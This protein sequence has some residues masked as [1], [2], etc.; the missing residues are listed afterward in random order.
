MSIGNNTIY[1]QNLLTKINL[2]PDENQRDM[3]FENNF[4]TRNISIYE[5][6]RLK[7]IGN[8][9]FKNCKNLTSVNFPN[10]ITI[11]N[12]A[13]AFCSNLTSINFPNCITVDNYAFWG[14]SALASISFPNCTDIDMQAFRGCYNLS[15]VYLTGSSLCKLYNSNVFISTPFMG[16]SSYF[17][18]TP[19]IYVP[20]SLVTSYQNATNWTY[21]S[22]YI[23]AYNP[24]ITFSISGIEYQAM[25]D[26]TWEEWVESQYNSSSF[27]VQDGKIRSSSASLVALEGVPVLKND[28]II[29]SKAYAFYSPSADY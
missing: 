21:F 4:I 16:Y 17:S 7:T 20:E 23:S 14:A 13:F 22:N 2:L 5:N 12:Y 27:S 11:G 3:D 15:Q 6:S 25:A 9:A 29:P 19:Y 24:T 1:L 10:C 18:G 26:M 28:K 8:Y